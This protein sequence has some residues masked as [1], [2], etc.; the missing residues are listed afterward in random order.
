V[1]YAAAEGAH[2]LGVRLAAWKAHHQVSDP[3]PLHVLPDAVDFLHGRAV[4]ALVA[5]V[6]RLR[7]A[8]VVLDTLSRGLPGHD[9]NQQDVMSA[10]VAGCACSGP[11]G[12]R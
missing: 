12:V 7:P 1:L 4:A 10:F 3:V 11:P 8:L 2:G 9:E 6:R 5:V